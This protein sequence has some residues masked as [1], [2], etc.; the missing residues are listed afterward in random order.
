MALLAK[1][2][3]IPM[4]VVVEETVLGF[5]LFI[6]FNLGKWMYTGFLGWT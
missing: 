5:K 2:F 3:S 4:M 1:A 6:V